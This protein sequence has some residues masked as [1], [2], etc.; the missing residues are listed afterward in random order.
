M[1]YSN[2]LSDKREKVSILSGCGKFEV[3]MRSLNLRSLCF[4]SG[5]IYYSFATKLGS[6]H[7]NQMIGSN[8]TLCNICA[9]VKNQCFSLMHI[10]ICTINTRSLFS[11]FRDSCTHRPNVGCLK[12]VK[13]H[14]KLILDTKDGFLVKILSYFPFILF[15]SPFQLLPQ[16]RRIQIFWD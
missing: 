14:Q 13:V 11:E 8:K 5:Q 10:Y 6:R 15:L 9:Q 4:C 1:N 12:V 7:Q 2:P 16:Q 3:T